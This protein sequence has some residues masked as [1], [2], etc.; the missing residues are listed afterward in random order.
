MH[1]RKS[2]KTEDENVRKICSCCLGEVIP[3][4]DFS[5]AAFSFKVLGDGFGVKPSDGRIVS[6]VN[7]VV[8]D[9]SESR[10]QV[11]LKTD[12]GF[13]FIVCIGSKTPNMQV[14]DECL[15][16]V[17][18]RVTVGTLFWNV[19]LKD[20]KSKN[21]EFLSAVVIT[22]SAKF[23]S[24]NINYGKVRSLNAAVMTAVL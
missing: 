13:I 8:K 18:Q 1:F 24:F 19:D 23:T 6:P 10:R 4:S 20:Y 7:G 12:D 16:S 15:V 21:V 2:N 5:N 17:G 9:I 11:T 22:N 14:N 3:L